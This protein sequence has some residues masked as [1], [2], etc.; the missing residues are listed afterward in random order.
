VGVSDKVVDFVNSGGGGDMI[1]AFG[2]SLMSSPANHWLSSGEVRA[3]L[4]AE[5]IS[6]G[7]RKAKYALP[8]KPS[9]LPSF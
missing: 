8:V 2:Y 7:C 4:E 9:E 3:C 1:R 6:R 5:S